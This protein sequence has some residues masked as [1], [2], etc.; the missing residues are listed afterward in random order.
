MV[1]DARL[2]RVVPG[3]MLARRDWDGEAVLFNDLSGDTH[4]LGPGALWLLDTL[5]AAPALD[6]TLAALLDD[7]QVLEATRAEL[8][9]LLEE[10]RSLNLVE[11]C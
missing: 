11:P 7:G 9:A 4:L 1:P 2:W 5:A 8:G 6:A 3:Q 10:L